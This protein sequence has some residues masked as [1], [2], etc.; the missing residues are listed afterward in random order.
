MTEIELI[1][2]KIELKKQYIDFILEEIM[3][4]RA[5]RHDLIELEFAEKK[6]VSERVNQ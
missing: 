2:R 1:D 4:L 5:K 3:E 6:R